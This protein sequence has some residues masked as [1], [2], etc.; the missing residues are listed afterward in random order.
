MKQ[1]IITAVIAAS[2]FL[3][4][5][6]I[7]KLPFIFLVYLMASIAL[8][9]MMRM[10]QIPSISLPA[11]VSLFSLWFFLLPTEYESFPIHIDMAIKGEIFLFLVLLLLIITVI[12]NNRYSFDEIGFLI[13]SV[14]YTGIGFYNLM[15]TRFT[16]L[17]FVFFSLFLIWATDSGAYFIGRA[18]G[19]RKLAPTISPNKTVEGAIG[20]IVF[21]IIVALSF[22]FFSDLQNGINLIRLIILSIFMS[23]FGQLGDLV[24]SALK[25][26]YGVKDS[27]SIL[28]GHGGILDRTDSWLFV[29]PLFQFLFTL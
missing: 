5:V 17:L 10:K 16:G 8:F 19:K 27:G 11:I 2:V 21:A 14:L 7:G 29:M 3:P 22:Y 9:E 20:G 28:P 1:R 15:A 26:H 25:R 18:F 13:L 4:I 12:S 24:E 6:Y 23:V